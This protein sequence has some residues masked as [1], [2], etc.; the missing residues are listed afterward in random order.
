MMDKTLENERVNDIVEAVMKVASGDYSV[1]VEL[2]GRND[3]LDSLAMSLNM[4][5]GDIRTGVE[6]L[7]RQRAELSAL[8]A[9]LQQEITER[10]RVE[11]EL[12]KA[13]ERY[14]TILDNVEDGY[15]EVDLAGNFTFVSDAVCRISAY[16]REEMMGTGYRTYAP[17]KDVKAAYEAFNRVYRTGKPMQDFR[18]GIFRKDGAKRFLETSAS[19]IRDP[20]GEI[21]GFRGV[22]RDVTE[23]KRAKETLQESEERFR[24][25]ADLLP[26]IVF[27]TDE[28]GNITFI[29]RHAFEVGGYGYTEEDLAKGWNALQMVDPQD[30][31]RA[32]QDML[33]RLGGEELAAGEYTGLRKDGSTSDCVKTGMA[34]D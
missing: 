18:G 17:E 26:Q 33:R 25:L 23:R 5:I 16:S 2:S 10:K 19:P 6:D 21:I 3:E 12:R 24:D 27:E 32:T 7:D 1:Q 9:Q 31:D 29:N 13:E 30:R 22:M 15:F 28:T 11:E 14:R 34:A 8:N 4:M 20:G